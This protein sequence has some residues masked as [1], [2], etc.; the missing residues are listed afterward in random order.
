MPGPRRRP[1]VPTLVAAPAASPRLVTRLVT[2]LAT[3]L[4]A[5]LA[6]CSAAPAPSRPADER[7]AA[8]EAQVTAGE[9]G[10]ALQELDDWPRDEVPPRLLDRRDLAQA[11]AL[12]A[13]DRAFEAFEVL[14]DLFAERPRSEL[15]AAAV[16]LQ[17]QIGKYLIGTGRSFWFFWS[18]RRAGRTVLEHL[19][20]NHPD[21]TEL[22][23]ALRLLG[24]L[25]FEDRDFTLAQARFRDLLRSRPESEWTVYARYRFAMSI[26]A[27][28]QGPAYDQ[29]RMQHAERE[30]REFLAGQPE[31]P[32]FVA[33]ATAALDRVVGWQAERELRIAHFY[34]TVDN[35]PG[36]RLHLDRACDE[37]FAGTPAGQQAR[38]EREQAAEAGR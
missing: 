29:D 37:R 12:F 17:W 34:R 19:V 21:S 36:Y 6:G 31:N 15:R 7:L 14:R 32:E 3:L 30:L 25:A 8:I 24:D 9:L 35:R 20:A 4:L 26:V 38:A 28:L 27:S 1:L 16:E 23:D 18:D 13:A 5:G 11:R 2:R 22:A 33:A 10:P